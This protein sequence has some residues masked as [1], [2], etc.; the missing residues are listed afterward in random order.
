MCCERKAGFQ[1]IAIESGVNEAYFFC[2][3][4]VAGAV[5]KC[6]TCICRSIGKCCN[7][8][9]EHVVTPLRNCVL[10]V[11]YG[12]YDH[13]MAPLGRGIYAVAAAMYAVA[14]RVAAAIYAVAARVGNAMYS[15][16]AEVAKS[17]YDVAWKKTETVPFPP[18]AALTKSI[19]R[20]AYGFNGSSYSLACE[21]NDTPPS[22]PAETIEAVMAAALEFECQGAHNHHQLLAAAV[23]DQLQSS[24]TS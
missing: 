21:V 8:V 14:A 12:I 7:W 3:D 18:T 23:V 15:V 24:S 6:C 5:G 20:K 19:T 11:M 9:G 10:A 1:Q 16:A 13:I 2:F 22:A 17:I 4:A